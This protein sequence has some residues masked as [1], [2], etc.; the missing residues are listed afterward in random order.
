[1]AFSSKA[2]FPSKETIRKRCTTLEAWA[3]PKQESTIA[4]DYVW[5]NKDMDPVP[6]SDQTWG[7]WTWI[8]Y[9]IIQVG[10]TWRDA[11]PIMAVGCLCVAIPVVLNGSMGAHLHV[12]FSVIVRSG[13]GYYFAYFCIASRCILAMFWLGIQSAN[14]A[15]AMQIM[16]MAIWPSFASYDWKGPN[17]TLSES[18]GIS[19][20]G[21]IAYFLFWI[22]QLPMLLIPPT[23]LRY[24]FIVKLIAAPVT[25]I[26][27]LGY[28]VHKA[29]GSG[30]IFS[31]PGTVTG[32]A[33]VYLWL[34]CMSSVTG[35]WAT[36]AV[37]VADFSRYAKGR[38][39][40]KSNHAQYI[41]LPALPIMFT[42]CGVLGVITTS[43]SKVVYGEFYWN[44][45][46]IVEQWL[47][48]G[49]AGRAAAFFAALSWF[50]AQ[51]GTNITGNSIS[52]ANDLCVMAPKYINIRRGCII[53][54]VVSCWVMVP[55]KILSD[56]ETFLSFM[57]G[58]S[59][60]LAPMAGI[61]AADYWLIKRRHIDV[62]ALYDP[63]GRYRYHYGVNWQGL[64]AFLVAVCPNLPGLANSIN[65]TSIS[66]GAKH[67]YSFDWLYGFVSS[68]FVYTVL[69]K[70]F[71]TKEALIPRSIYSLEVVEGKEMSS[72]RDIE[73]ESDGI[74][75]KKGGNVEAVDFG[76]VL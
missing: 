6:I 61:I 5:T 71:P 18:G 52:A 38:A 22:I 24:L 63:H 3:L 43:A 64:A 46:N 49:H 58:Y 25:A 72:D 76:K 30:A 40:G 65:A 73:G 50:I 4:P 2:V 13:F 68:I 56:A 67:L 45:L 17:N 7:M 48:N 54:A 1:M 74:F 15:L 34:S 53:S 60:F 47:K 16:I 11:I 41:Q 21:M 10:L 14:G 27:T 29:G 31:Q 36:L 51:V 19:T 12:P 39:D 20:A 8:A 57:S 37:N 70:I 42:L 59:V 23:R 55:W 69:S 28:M 32:D 75:E 35:V 33:R 62:P 66:A 44:P 9:S 26:A